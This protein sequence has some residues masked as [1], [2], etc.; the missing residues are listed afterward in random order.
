MIH[1]PCVSTLVLRPPRAS[2]FVVAVQSIQRLSSRCGRWH[3]FFAF[4][5]ALFD[6]LLCASAG[7]GRFRTLY[8]VEPVSNCAPIAGGPTPSALV[9][10]LTR[11]GDSEVRCVLGLA[12]R[13]MTMA[14][15][16]ISFGATCFLS[17]AALSC[18][19]RWA[20]DAARRWPFLL[21]RRPRLRAVGSNL[22]PPFVAEGAVRWRASDS[23]LRHSLR[24]AAW[25]APGWPPY[26]ERRFGR[27]PA[28]YSISESSEVDF[29]MAERAE[30]SDTPAVFVEGTPEQRDCSGVREADPV[31]TEA[32]AELAA[33][34]L[35][36]VFPDTAERGPTVARLAAL[37]VD[38]VERA[39]AAPNP[40]WELKEMELPSEC[41][42][43][44]RPSC[45]LSDRFG[46]LE[47]EEPAPTE[48]GLFAGDT[49]YAP[50]PGRPPERATPCRGP[51]AP[52]EV[53]DLETYLMRPVP[54]RRRTESARVLAAHASFLQYWYRRTKASAAA[55]L[56]LHPDAPTAWSPGGMRG[57]LPIFRPVTRTRCTDGIAS[58]DDFAAQRRRARRVLM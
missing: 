32:E 47:L 42:S 43:D 48:D 51:R 3:V 35:G 39:A 26:R 6:A 10:C 14:L 49:A 7:R 58:E 33:T 29:C 9:P 5:R 36:D 13:S 28:L 19:V 2:E 12:L 1:I 56:R 18:L 25:N 20:Y 8:F 16:S 45:L 50:P 17:T 31:S 15:G 23:P 46:A 27:A 41:P 11:P 57:L 22:T 4:A 54:M 34:S 52:R 55:R 24:M 38:E 40:W 30:M 21:H 44:G 53:R 37:A